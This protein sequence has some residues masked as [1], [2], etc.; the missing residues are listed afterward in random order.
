MKDAKKP[1]RERSTPCPVCKTRV[2]KLASHITRQHAD[3]A[4]QEGS[5][6]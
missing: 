3:E 1:W 6:Q 5:D 4:P 2:V